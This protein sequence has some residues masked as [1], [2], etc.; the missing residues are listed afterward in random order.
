M[1][2]CYLQPSFKLCT[3][4]AQKQYSLTPHFRTSFLALFV[5]YF[6]NPSSSSVTWKSGTN[7]SS[8][9]PVYQEQFKVKPVFVCLLVFGFC[10]VTFWLPAGLIVQ[11]VTSLMSSILTFFLVLKQSRVTT[12]FKQICFFSYSKKY[13][14]RKIVHLQLYSLTFLADSCQEKHHQ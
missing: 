8:V 1:I 4:K 11:I 13:T 7:Q 2:Y 12:S 9:L 10:S 3:S 5:F 14:G 6:S